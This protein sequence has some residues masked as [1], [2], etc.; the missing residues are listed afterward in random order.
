M[1][2]KDIYE[3]LLTKSTINNRTNK[4]LVSKK[5]KTKNKK[6]KKI[7]L[8]NEIIMMISS[9]FNFANRQNN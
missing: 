9:F 4:K 8:E 1:F 3:I 7:L 5:Y 6:P 2:N